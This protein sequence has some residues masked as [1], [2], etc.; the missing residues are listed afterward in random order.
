MLHVTAM[1][2]TEVVK[3]GLS[4]KGHQRSRRGRDGWNIKIQC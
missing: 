4:E 3:L 2:H 1:A